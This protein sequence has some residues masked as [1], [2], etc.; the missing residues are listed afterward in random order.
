MVGTWN[1]AQEIR[2]GK[3]TREEGIKLV[4]L[5][6]EEF[7][8]KYFKE[9]LEYININEKEFHEIVD[10]FRS[11]HLWKFVGNNWELKHSCYRDS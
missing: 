9:F 5:Y 6:D 11:P 7:P 8:N 4:E 2:N 10:K 3:I 1:T